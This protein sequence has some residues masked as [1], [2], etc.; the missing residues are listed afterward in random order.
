MEAK[1]RGEFLKKISINGFSITESGDQ[2]ILSPRG[3]EDT[4]EIVIEEA[5]NNEW[6]VVSAS[7]N[8][9]AYARGKKRSYFLTYVNQWAVQSILLA[10]G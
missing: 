3:Y 1:A 5:E 9:A 2:L 10:R 4:G 6:R 7:G 8:F